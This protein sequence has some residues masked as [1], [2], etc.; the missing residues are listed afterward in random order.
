[1]RKFCPLLSGHVKANQILM[2]ILLWLT[3][4]RLPSNGGAKGSKGIKAIGWHVDRT[5]KAYYHTWDYEDCNHLFH[6]DGDGSG[7][8]YEGFQRF[9][10]DT[11]CNGI[12]GNDGHEGQD[13]NP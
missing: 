1:M 11:P 4:S 13:W 7:T 5:F 2:H 6:C 12:N 3:F 10:H 8:R 9:V